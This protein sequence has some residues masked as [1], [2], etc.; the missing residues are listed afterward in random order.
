[1]TSRCSNYPPHCV[2]ACRFRSPTRL[3]TVNQIRR[4][5]RKEFLGSNSQRGLYFTP[6]LYDA[7]VALLRRAKVTALA[8][9]A[10][11]YDEANMIPANEP[12]VPSH[13]HAREGK[14]GGAVDPTTDRDV[15]VGENVSVST[16][17][18]RPTS[19]PSAPHL[20]DVDGGHVLIS[21]QAVGFG[22]LAS[23]PPIKDNTSHELGVESDTGSRSTEQLSRSRS[24]NEA[25]ATQRVRTFGV[26]ES[27][28]VTGVEALRQ[29][30]HS[31][32]CGEWD[33][34]VDTV[35]QAIDS[36][37]AWIPSPQEN[38]VESKSSDEVAPEILKGE[39]HRRDESGY[40]EG[41]DGPTTVE[42]DVRA[43]S[44]SEGLEQA[45]GDGGLAGSD[46][47]PSDSQASDTAS[48]SENVVGSTDADESADDEEE[49]FI[50]HPVLCEQMELRSEW[51]RLVFDAQL[52]PVMDSHVLL[53]QEIRSMANAVAGAIEQAREQAGDLPGA[54][55]HSRV[56]AILGYDKA[57]YLRCIFLL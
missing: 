16:S 43:D 9:Q 42:G 36:L 31:L 39:S 29:M 53:R 18:T 26:D 3:T 1:M 54:E 56:G 49:E 5:Q 34:S 33:G 45:M 38:V 50:G 48:D 10:G 35:L 23:S 22:N 25:A 52:E 28:D 32:N 11:Q 57:R 40:Q 7:F 12:E 37:S 20:T 13:E 51:R 27:N 41:M 55:E 19:P 17:S 2:K 4:R 14:V 44:D 46:R 6:E 8:A 30:L 47:D 15:E 21:T 24:E